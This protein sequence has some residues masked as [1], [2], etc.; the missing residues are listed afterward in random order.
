MK[1]GKLLDNRS[2]WLMLVPVIIYF[3][4]FKYLP[5]GGMLIAFQRYSPYRGFFGS[6]WVGFEYF[7]QFFSSIYFGR[8]LR[9][10]LMIGLFYLVF[11]FPM[12]IGLALIINGIPNG[13][14]KKTTQTITLL[15]HFVSFV[16]IAGI[17]INFL[18]PSVGVINAIIELF[19]GQPIYFMQEPQLFWPIYT[20]IRIFKETGYEAIVYLAALSAIDPVLYESASIDGA[21]TRQKLFKITLPSITPTIIIM[22]LVRVGR[23]VTVS[24]EEVLLLQNNVILSTSEVISTFVYRRG[25]VGGGYSYAVA[26]GLLESLV[27]LILVVGSNKLA[28]RYS[29]NTLW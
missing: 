11:A 13:L 22:F 17:A 1:T 28:R 3:V 25:L 10:T 23:L 14:F 16:V 19:G 8:V 21:S 12:P 26:V 6:E 20:A 5:L 15:P 24:F 9:N 4:V 29:E 18:S 7:I 2:L 27:A